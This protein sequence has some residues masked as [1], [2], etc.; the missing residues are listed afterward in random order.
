MS[1]VFILSFCGT[2]SLTHQNNDPSRLVS[3][4]ANAKQ[5][6]D[7][8]SEVGNELES[9]IERA[10]VKLQSADLKTA[11]AISAELNTIIRFYEERPPTA[12]DYHL[13]LCTDTWLGEQAAQLVKDWLKNYTENVEVRRQRDLQTAALESF[14][15]ALSEL[16]QWC[17]ETLPV[18]RQRHY[19]I[20]VI[21]HG[22]EAGR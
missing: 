13:L 12:S 4:Y 6:T 19:R 22:S 17:E 5:K 16:V 11:A 15:I 18:F 9:V 2:S 3:K 1:Q 10:R 21:T 20:I 14:Q 7:F 8:P